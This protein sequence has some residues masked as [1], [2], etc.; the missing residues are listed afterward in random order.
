[1]CWWKWYEKVN[2]MPNVAC[3]QIQNKLIKYCRKII[4]MS[5]KLQ[6][7]HFKWYNL[8]ISYRDSSNFRVQNGA[9]MLNFVLRAEMILLSLERCDKIHRFYVQ[10][11][12]RRVLVSEILRFIVTTIWLIFNNTVEPWLTG[13]PRKAVKSGLYLFCMHRASDPIWL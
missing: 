10:S 5:F 13:L 4:C 1:M 8:R 2:L 9:K 11:L 6:W 12:H 7:N 3:N